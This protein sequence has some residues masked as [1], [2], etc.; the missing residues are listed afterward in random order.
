MTSGG[1]RLPGIAGL[2]LSLLLAAALVLLLG[3][4]EGFSLE[5]LMEKLF[6]GNL[7]IFALICLSTATHHALAA[8]K[9]RMATEVIDPTA[10]FRGGY[11]FY[12]NL[13]HLTA[14]FLPLQLSTMFVRSL[15]MRLHLRAPLR[16]GAFAAGFDLLF[17]FSISLAAALG[18]A[19][20]LI[21]RPEPAV[22]LALVAAAAF[23]GMALPPLLLAA[24]HGLRTLL[25]TLLRAGSQ[26]Q[27]LAA[28]FSTGLMWRLASL[29]A[30]RFVN[31]L[32]DNYLVVLMFGLDIPPYAIILAT[33]VVQ[34]A[35]LL[36]LTPANLGISE[37]S[38]VGVMAAFG[39]AP[40]TAAAY[41]LLKR[42]VKIPAV[43]LATAASLPGALGSGRALGGGEG[44]GPQ[45]G[46]EAA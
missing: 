22:A 30:A 28:L 7:A 8:R 15:A 21:L 5:L 4:L 1:V 42:L 11:F 20:A 39:V 2:I 9:W 13:S 23:A 14:Q 27:H 40:A 25:L 32:A 3:N 26:R 12:S 44:D 17:D 41:A 16:E 10:R 43:A 36:S 19:A 38:W 29:S 37:W 45:R 35:T 6:A 18:A 33:P 46:G 24:S 31:L 34:L